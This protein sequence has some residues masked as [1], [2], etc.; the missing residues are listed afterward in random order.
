MKKLLEYTVLGGLL[1]L[2]FSSCRTPALIDRTVNRSVPESYGLNSD[3]LN[4]AQVARDEF[5]VDPYLQA[6]ID[7][8]ISN[9]QELQIMLMETEISGYEVNARS[10][11]VLPSASVGGGAGLDKTARYTPLGANEATTDIRPG[12]EMPD[13]VPDYFVGA[14][15]SW[16]VDIWNKLRNAKRAAFNRYLATV[17]GRNFMVTN[18]VAE[19][20]ST[21]YELLALDGQLEIVRQ[22]I[23]IQTDALKT[24]RL[25]KQ[26]ARV[27]G[28]AVRRFEAQLLAT[29]SLEYELKQAIVEA[30]NR[31]NF[32]V[33]RF[34]QPVMRD[35]ST[36]AD[37][38][39]PHIDEGIPV[40]LLENRPD[41]RAAELEL[42]AADLD[43]KAAKAHFYP[44]LDVS[45]A[46]GL[47]AY[48]PDLLLKTPESMLFS[49]AGDLAAPLI[50]RKA[51][52][53]AFQTANARQ[54][55]AIYEYEQTLLEAYIEVAN[56]LSNVENLNRVY[57]LQSERVEALTESIELA[58][59]LFGSARADY[60]E[61]LF[62]Q[63]DALEST[64]ELIETKRRRLN[65]GIELYRALGGGWK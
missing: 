22:N 16:E 9:N 55:Q 61:V 20:A 2:S 3:T 51:I 13:P 10:G 44:A 36:F 38:K 34:P 59:S 12:T 35:S 46:I 60:T 4:S 64:F 43:V 54:V 52:M 41:V 7:T 5:F 26:S 42:A 15:A 62:T 45:A 40:Q 57:D 31:I 29:R 65:A 37:L 14:F 63:R 50:N 32:L 19:I 23:S 28:L 21:Y 1:I 6:L 11:E 48:K 17:E 39:L 27:T 25:Q 8:A 47:N 18:L 30:E 49:L 24:I 33:G 56:Q 58:N 53:A